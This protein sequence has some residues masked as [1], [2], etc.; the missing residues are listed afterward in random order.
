MKKLTHT[1]DQHTIPKCYLKNFSDNETHLCR[2]FKIAHIDDSTVENEL[3]SF[4]SLKKATVEEDF[5]TVSGVNEPMIVETLIYSREIEV[6]YPRIYKL[7]VDPKIDRFDMEV[8]TRLLWFLLSLHCRTPKQFRL[9]E[10][11]IP[12]YPHSDRDKIMDDYKV[13]HVQ[14]VLPAV[15][16]AHQFKKIQILR[17]TDTS[18]FI[19]SDNS[20]LI[21]NS[22]SS[23]KNL[24]YKEQFNSENK[25]FIPL[26]TKHCC[27]LTNCFDK[28][29]IDSYGKV[30]YNKIERIDVDCSISQQINYLM[31]SS[32]DKYYF[33][34]EKYM[35][36]M[37]NLYKLV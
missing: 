1:K 26:D 12:S 33:G 15:I 19:T 6:H 30:F 35:T 37:F 21:I 13:I 29:G 9:Y 10:T 28:N 11:L 2:K 32:A 5:Y 22:D 25:I 4:V 16:A 3:K 24:D 23:L 20:V 8:R 27:L 34:S 17:L 31:L 7:L 14:D 18:H 36:G